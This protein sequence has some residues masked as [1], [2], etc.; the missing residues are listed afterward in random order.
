MKI[1][2]S[3]HTSSFFCLS[4]RREH[5]AGISLPSEFCFSVLV[6][7][8]YVR[9]IMSFHSLVEEQFSRFY[10][11]SKSGSLVVHLLNVNAPCMS[12]FSQP[13]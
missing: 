1:L 3:G 9:F 11:S 4:V 12:E 10:P 13:G 8:C 2:P 7:Y 6:L 5:I